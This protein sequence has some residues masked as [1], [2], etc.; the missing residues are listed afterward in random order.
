[1]PKKKNL[2]SFVIK[3][4]DRTGNELALS[5]VPLPTLAGASSEIGLHLRLAYR[6]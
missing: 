3:S 2:Q 4:K 6:S 1:M 5:A